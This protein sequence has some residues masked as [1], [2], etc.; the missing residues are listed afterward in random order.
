MIDVSPYPMCAARL[1]FFRANLAEQGFTYYWAAVAIVADIS[2]KAL[3][4][5]GGFDFADKS[6]DNGKRLLARLDQFIKNGLPKKAKSD[7]GGM[8]AAEASVRAMLGANGIKV[9][10]LA[11][12][13]DYWAVA[14]VLWPGHVDERPKVADVYTLNFQLQKIPKKARGRSAKV[15]LHLVRAEWRA[16]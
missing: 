11:G 4:R 3:K 12:V 5:F 2:D 8:S 6:D 9:S 13:D 10:K 7:K 16:A 15:K 14:R 1:K